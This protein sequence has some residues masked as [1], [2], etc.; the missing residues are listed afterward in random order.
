MPRISNLTSISSAADA[1]EV[2]LVDTSAGQTKRITVANLL[3]PLDVRVT[4]LETACEFGAYSSA[5]TTVTTSPT[6]ITLGNELF[7]TGSNFDNA[8]NYR[9]VAPVTG[10]YSFSCRV[11][12]ATPGSGVLCTAYLYKNGSAFTQDLSVA[13]NNGGANSVN[14]AISATVSLTATDYVELYA[15]RGSGS[16]SGDGTLSGHLIRTA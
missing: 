16:G 7:D 1:D 9:F 4:E 14:L 12:L 15:K 11:T 2:A 10:Y 3:S 5:S 8:T 6:K 13:L